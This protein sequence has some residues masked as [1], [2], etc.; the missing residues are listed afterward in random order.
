MID[1]WLRNQLYTLVSQRG[2]WVEVYD[3]VDGIT[4][5]DDTTAEQKER[6]LEKYLEYFGNN[7]RQLSVGFN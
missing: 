7:I 2:W 5:E 1:W 3:T 4:V 6:G